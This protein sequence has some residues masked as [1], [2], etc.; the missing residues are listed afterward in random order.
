MIGFFLKKAFFDGWDN[1]LTIALFNLGYVVIIA[2][3]LAALSAVSTSLPLTLLVII[4]C[5]VLFYLYSGGVA[6]YMGELAF[7]KSPELR[8]FFVYCKESLK[9]SLTLAG[10]TGLQLVLLAVAFPF[11]LSMGG[12]LSMAAL[13][14]LFWVS[15]LWWLVSL[16]VY[17]VS[18]QLET[19]VKL[20]LKKSLLIFLDNGAFTLFL[21]LYSFVNFLL[22]LVTAFLIPGFTGIRYSRQ[23]ALK[24]RMFKYDYLEENPGVDRKLIPWSA[25]L[26]EENEKLGHRS[27]RGMIFPWKD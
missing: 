11:Y 22:S 20:Q 7:D 6:R 1:L 19:S 23:I 26:R 10:I 18:M 15:V 2:I 16:W 14:I 9:T 4:F 13:S 3:T 12:I 5:I 27:L 25:L 8:Y 17:P 24:L 21:A